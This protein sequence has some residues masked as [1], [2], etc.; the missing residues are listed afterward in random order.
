MKGGLFF[1]FFSPLSFFSPPNSKARCLTGLPNRKLAES[2]ITGLVLVWVGASEGLNGT[3]F[4]FFG[5]LFIA[6]ELITA[7]HLLSTLKITN[8][9]E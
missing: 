7:A 9:N 8:S 5:T 2:D 4:K 6:Y 3:F 1:H